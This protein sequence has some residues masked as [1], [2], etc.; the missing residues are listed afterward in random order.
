MSFIRTFFKVIFA[1]LLAIS[2]ILFIIDLSFI[3]TTSYENL[4]PRMTIFTD[5][6]ISSSLDQSTPEDLSLLKT[7]LLENCSGQQETVFSLGEQEFLP[8]NDITIDCSK[9][10][11][12]T[13]TEQLINVVSS[14]VF[15]TIYNKKYDC[16][17]P[18]CLSTMDK[19]S[20]NILVLVS[21]KAYRLTYPAK[22]QKLPSKKRR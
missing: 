16:A 9:I 13:T 4:Q 14:S 10:S 8:L 18:D 20:S 6:A 21:K 5:Q 1:V 12:E 19:D 2:L 17:I 7:M 22:C 11:N 3:G 15:N